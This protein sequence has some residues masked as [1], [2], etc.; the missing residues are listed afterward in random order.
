MGACPA[1]EMN[2]RRKIIIQTGNE[3]DDP[4]STPHFDTEATLT[5][6]P[7]VPL[8]EGAA[9][10]GYGPRR[11]RTGKSWSPWLLVLI[12][13]GAVS[14][15]V[16]T[17]LGIGFYK[18]RQATAPPVANEAS[19]PAPDINAGKTVELPA[20]TPTPQPAQEEEA[21]ASVPEEIAEEP[22]VQPKDEKAERAARDERDNDG[23]KV[24][25]PVAPEKR[26][27]ADDE[28]LEGDDEARRAER[29]RRREERRERRR[30]ERELE[31]PAEFPRD[32]E[33][34]GREQINRIRDI[35][36]G[37]EP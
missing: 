32:I 28:V 35:F 14:L 5:A 6:R 27:E 33:R 4:L 18:N 8:A 24:T 26:R 20:P 2:E 30:R 7:V 12:V 10:Q 16:A 21:R 17:G 37:R 29:Q 34:A 15:G 1:K 13:T 3:T 31:L 25:P 9:V 11:L 22:S 19:A 36:E 23:G